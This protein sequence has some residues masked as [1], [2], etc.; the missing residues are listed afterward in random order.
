MAKKKIEEDKYIILGYS[1]PDVDSYA[2]A[3]QERNNIELITDKL[4]MKDVT[5]LM[6]LYDIL[7][8]SKKLKSV[9]TYDFLNHIKKLIINEEP[10]LEK[11]LEPIN[12]IN[13]DLPN[14]TNEF[15]VMQKHNENTKNILLLDTYKTKMR[16]SRIIN[17]FL[18]II[19]I[20]MLAISIYSDRTVYQKFEESVINKYSA[21]QEDLEI[22]EKILKEQEK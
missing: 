8:S 3:Q 19:I 22:R 10:E 15:I 4:D 14:T 20:V 6:K 12:I 2:Q 16:N 21:W 7:N 9:I 17:I 1:F 13:D 5:K 11:Q 18:T